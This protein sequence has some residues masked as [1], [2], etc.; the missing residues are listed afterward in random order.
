MVS[1]DGNEA[2]TKRVTKVA[3]GPEHSLGFPVEGRTFCCCWSQSLGSVSHRVLNARDCIWLRQDGA[4]S[5]L[6]CVHSEEERLALIEGSQDRPGDQGF[7]EV[8]EG[9]EGFW[10]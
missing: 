10:R 3:E 9:F 7:F 8:V 2:R 1:P 6:R 5:H 4:M